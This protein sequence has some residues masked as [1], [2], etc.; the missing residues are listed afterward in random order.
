MKAQFAKDDVA[1]V[2]ALPELN[3][4]VESGCMDQAKDIL[5][6]ADVTTNEFRAWKSYSEPIAAH[7]ILA[8]KQQNDDKM[9]VLIDNVLTY[10]DLLLVANKG[11]GKTN[12]LMVLAQKFRNLADTR[13]IIFEDFPKWCLEFDALPYMV[14]R[15]SDVIE[16]VHAIDMGGYFLKHEQDYSVKHCDK[17]QSFLDGNKDVIFTSE[18]RDIER[19]AFFIYSVVDYFYRKAYL[20][21]FKG[22]SKKERVI[23]IIEESQN[24]FDSSIISRK[25]FNRL[26]KIFSVARNL[27]LHFVLATQRLQD[28]NT[29]IRGRTRLLLGRV[30]LDDYELK[31]NRLL[32]HSKHRTA[33]LD[34]ERGTF[35][36]EATD[37]VVQF[38]KFATDGK[39]FEWD[40]TA[41]TDRAQKPEK[42][43]WQTVKEVMNGK[44]H[45]KIERSECIATVQTRYSDVELRAHNCLGD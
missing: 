11:I 36:Y 1:L 33:I 27:D 3:E 24:V 18:I 13:V 23:F 41:K 22:Y 30:S 43:L 38:P 17:I 44:K 39:P 40:S 5:M 42:S 4:L 31:V 20:R 29:K 16:T 37:S 45:R 14:I 9:K 10:G 32:R 19:Q 15:D 7:E 28:L 25:I 8:V 6:N 12:T 26:R 34:F 2:D 35:L 21:R